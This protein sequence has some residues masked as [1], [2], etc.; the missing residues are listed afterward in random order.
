VILIPPL[1]VLVGT[2]LAVATGPGV[3]SMS[4]PG[5]HGFS[6]ALYA[7][8]SAGNNNGIAFAGLVADTPFY[9]RA[10]GVAMRLAFGGLTPDPAPVTNSACYSPITMESAWWLTAVFAY[11]RATQAMAAV[12]ES[13]RE[14]ASRTTDGSSRMDKWFTA[15]MTE[16]FS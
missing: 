15:L 16:T 12:P 3:S 1:V 10:L 14:A 4:N 8:S 7:F 6:E 13:F 5:P 11:D 2:A 9:N